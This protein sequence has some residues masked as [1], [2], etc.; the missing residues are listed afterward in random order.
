MG[1]NAVVGP[2]PLLQL[3]VE[4]RQAPGFGHHLIEL[5]VVGAM[6]A[7]DGAI[8]FRRPWRKHE[9]CNLALL[10]SSLELRG[11]LTAAID[12]QSGDAERHAL[13]QHV[14]EPRRG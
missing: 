4:R 3:T 7:L 5:L 10:A 8:E 12:L 9:Q 14:E 2:L 11:E 6:G 13:Q 1:A